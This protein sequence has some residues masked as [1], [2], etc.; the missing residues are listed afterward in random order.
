VSEDMELLADASH[1]DKCHGAA[2]LYWCK[3]DQK[4]YPLISTNIRQNWRG[5]ADFY[6]FLLNGTYI[7]SLKV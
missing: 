1:M 5:L 7:P 4:N 2:W 6:G 3:S